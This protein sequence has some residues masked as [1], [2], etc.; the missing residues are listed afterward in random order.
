MPHTVT[1]W[2]PTEMF[3]GR[4]IRTRIDLIK[5]HL[6]SGVNSNLHKNNLTLC[7][8]YPND[9]VIVSRYRSKHKWQHGKIVE[10]ISCK[11]YKV[12]INGKIE[13]K[14]IDQIKKSQTT[15]SNSTKDD[16]WDNTIPLMEPT[17]NNSPGK[18]YPTRNRKPVLRYGFED[19]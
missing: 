4:N 3:I 5:P 6:T 7:T 8:L 17:L 10:R 16:I 2:T 9:L 12:L 18:Q 11:M 1:N 19:K 14:H 13:E 15:E